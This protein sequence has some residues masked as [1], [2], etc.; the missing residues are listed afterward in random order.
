VQNVRNDM[1]LVSEAV[2]LT[3]SAQLSADDSA[4]LKAYSAGVDAATKFIPVWV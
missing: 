1:Y 3:P 4:A 2:R